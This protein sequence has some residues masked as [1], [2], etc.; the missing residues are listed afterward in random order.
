MLP[1]RQEVL[2][3]TRGCEHLLSR[4]PT[5]TDDERNLVEYYV[6][7]LFSRVHVELI[8]HPSS[9]QISGSTKPTA[10]TPVA[11]FPWPV[12]APL[13]DSKWVA[14]QTPL[15]KGGLPARQ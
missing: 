10:L 13:P 6:N 1:F 9:Q 5:L 2:A 4:K 7:D 12:Y 8:E 15:P 3:F 11:P 14:R